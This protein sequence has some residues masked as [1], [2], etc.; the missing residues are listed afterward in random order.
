MHVQLMSI[1]S[2]CTQLSWSL[3]AAV[4]VTERRDEQDAEDQIFE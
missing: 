1:K 3:K 4:L 2:L